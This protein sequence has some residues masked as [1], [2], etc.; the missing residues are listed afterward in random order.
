M[1]EATFGVRVGA[2]LRRA[3]LDHGWT[4]AEVARFLG[5]DKQAIYRWE[6]GRCEISL[7]TLHDLARLYGLTVAYLVDPENAMP[8]KK[9]IVA[10]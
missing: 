3:R 2:T 9:K 7:A 5:R 10:A 4:M 8:P 6:A 1:G